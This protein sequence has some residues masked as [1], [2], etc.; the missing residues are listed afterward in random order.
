MLEHFFDNPLVLERL[1]SGLLSPHLDSFAASLAAL[2]YARFTGRAQLDLLGRMG[3]WLAGNALTV[4]DL[5]E[6][7]VSRFLDEECG[8]GH[9]RRGD[10]AT[11][12]RFLEHLHRSGVIPVPEGVSDQHPLALIES[13]YAHYLRVERGLSTATV[14]NY[15][16][17]IHR[18]LVERFRWPRSAR[19]CAI[20]VPT[21]R[22]STPRWT[23]KGCGRWRSP[24]HDA[25]CSHERAG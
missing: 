15:V 24:G 11:G 13:R 25:R 23:S 1:R 14:H 17:F 8:Q 18:F 6:R 19:S 20:A 3:R 7:V 2:G 10:R 22:R 9:L 5:D 4:A 12:R 21:P 16:P